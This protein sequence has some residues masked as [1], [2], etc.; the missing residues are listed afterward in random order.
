MQKVEG[1]S[2]FIRF[3]EPAANC[4]PLMRR[5]LESFSDAEILAMA[6]AVFNRRSGSQE[7]VAAHRRRLDVPSP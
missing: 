1:S 3:T 7:A 5:W 4:E 2:P 6:R